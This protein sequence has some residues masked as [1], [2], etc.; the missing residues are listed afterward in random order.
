MTD[1]RR[2]EGLGKSNF[3]VAPTFEGIQLGVL[4]VTVLQSGGEQQDRQE[5]RPRIFSATN[6]A[7][8]ASFTTVASP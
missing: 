5:M 2:S 8:T 7:P 1:V 6:N 3:R 4:T